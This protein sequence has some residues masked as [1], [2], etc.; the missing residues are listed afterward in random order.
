M[1]VYVIGGK[2]IAII[3]EEDLEKEIAGRWNTALI[4]FSEFYLD[5]I[6]DKSILPWKLKKN[7]YDGQPLYFQSLNDGLEYIIANGG[8]HIQ[9]HKGFIN[10]QTDD[11]IYK[12]LAA[13]SP[14]WATEVEY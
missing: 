14:F 2:F 11:Q 1:K 3:G 12:H 6:D 8:D 4:H 13:F 7:R 10:L 9:H 5:K